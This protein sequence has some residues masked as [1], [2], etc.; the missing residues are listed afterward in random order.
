MDSTTLDLPPLPPGATLDAAPAGL[1]PLPSG[2]KLDLP[3][4]PPGATLDLPPLPPGAKLDASPS[5]TAALS[6][7]IAATR[8][9]RGLTGPMGMQLEPGT[10]PL[11]MAPGGPNTHVASPAEAG[12]DLAA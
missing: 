11:Q 12:A 10:E 7:P 1:P 4:L 3:P 6:Q 5:V 2:A 8:V 9:A